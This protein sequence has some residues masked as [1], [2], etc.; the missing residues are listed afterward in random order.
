[1]RHESCLNILTPAIGSILEIPK[2]G[3]FFQKL[4]YSEESPPIKLKFRKNIWMSFPRLFNKGLMT[5]YDLESPIY[6]FK[7]GSL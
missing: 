3:Y 4:V 6:N 2:N 7:S 5:I 1:M